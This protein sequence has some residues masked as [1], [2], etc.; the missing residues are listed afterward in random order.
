VF[1]KLE[2]EGPVNLGGTGLKPVAEP[3]ERFTLAIPV[4]DDLTGFTE[5]ITKFETAQPSRLGVVPPAGLAAIRR[6]RLASLRT[7]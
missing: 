1:Y 3:S 7:V 4:A 6:Y 2:H 5:K